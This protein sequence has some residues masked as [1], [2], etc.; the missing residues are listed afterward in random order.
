ML[1]DNI[2][3]KGSDSF[4]SE[5][6]D[7]LLFCAQVI[8]LLCLPFRGVD[9]QALGCDGFL[10]GDILVTCFLVLLGLNET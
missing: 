1:K 4:P 2:F 6:I 9:W 5:L 10:F 8:W 3:L 7:F